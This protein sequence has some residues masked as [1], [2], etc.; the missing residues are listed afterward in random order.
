MPDL[1]L[2]ALE[3]RYLAAIGVAVAG[4]RSSSA[5]PE[6]PSDGAAAASVSAPVASVVVD[7]PPVDAAPSATATAS[8]PAPPHHGKLLTRGQNVGGAGYCFPAERADGG[9][10]AGGYPV[11]ACATSGWA[12]VRP[13]DEPIAGLHAF[14]PTDVGTQIAR[15][16]YANA[17]CYTISRPPRGR[18]L[19]VGGVPTVAPV[20]PRADWSRACPV[21]TAPPRL[22]A[23]LERAWRE[24]ARVEHASVASFARFA[25]DLL[26]LGAPPHL[27]EA[28]HR[29]ALE[30][31]EHTKICFG[32]ARRYGGHDVGPAPLVVPA[33]A[34]A[35][36]AETIAFETFVD[37][38]IGETIAAV[39]ARAAAAR[40][41][42]PSTRRALETIA[43][44]EARHAELAWAAFA[45]A[46]PRTA[47]FAARL[48]EVL[49]TRAIDADDESD[50]LAD[51]GVLGARERRAIAETVTRHVIRPCFEAWR[52]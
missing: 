4:C 19:R 50:D 27:V 9:V 3:L 44:D 20:E 6:P 12:L 40:A 49:Q 36:D 24:A 37:G 13:D 33:V 28:A 1:S 10:G 38:C 14:S 18:A 51:Y 23:A 8:D 11:A 39:E 45:F 17:C 32:E 15:K 30:E 47:T 21:A 5:R 34:G 7:A 31:I 35:R 46:A 2:K 29:A 26:A 22:H 48:E 25:L 52:A 41:I 16:T 42:E 43:E